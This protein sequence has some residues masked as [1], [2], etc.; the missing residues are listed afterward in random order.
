MSKILVGLMNAAKILTNLHLWP[1]C[2]LY[3]CQIYWYL[4]YTN[5]AGRPLLNLF[6]VLKLIKWHKASFW[7]LAL[8]FKLQ[9][10]FPFHLYVMDKSCR[11]Q[12]NSMSLSCEAQGQ[13]IL[14]Q[15]TLY[16]LD[17]IWVKKCFKNYCL[18]KKRNNKPSNK[19]NIY[20]WGQEGSSCVGVVKASHTNK[21]K[22]TQCF[23]TSHKLHRQYEWW[24]K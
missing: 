6:H 24:R 18:K 17:L 23:G 22:S 8:L 13:V 19:N 15:V 3:S 9:E 5:F 16:F 7:F 1:A 2:I 21:I 14:Q 10:V 20:R 11:L 12:T 4:H